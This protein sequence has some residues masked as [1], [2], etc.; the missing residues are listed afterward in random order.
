MVQ[1]IHFIQEGN[2]L[3]LMAAVLIFPAVMTFSVS[4]GEKSRLFFRKQYDRINNTLK[5]RKTPLFDY[6]NIQRFLVKNGAAFHIR[7]FKNPTVYLTVRMILIFLGFFAGSFVHTGLGII[8]AVI[9]FYLINAYLAYCNKKDN[10]TMAEDIQ[11]MY[12]S[13]HTQIKAGIYPADALCEIAES[14]KSKRLYYA[15]NE[16]KGDLLVHVG[17][18]DAVKRME[19]KFNN[20][21]ITALSLTLTQASETGCALELL[22]DLSDQ[23]TTMR[24][25]E[26]IAKKGKLD[27]LIS[28]CELLLLLVGI[29]FIVMISFS[30][31]ETMVDGL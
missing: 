26:L 15:L 16:L 7:I 3:P 10:E 27:R 8:L 2:I 11:I 1:F 22:N 4:A 28:V 31:I 12:T 14:I 30:G 5:S 21:Y 9:C 13:L 23:I 25:A 20:R 29:L 19:S 6:D 24:N 18:K 17:F